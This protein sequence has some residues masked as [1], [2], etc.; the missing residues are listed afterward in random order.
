MLGGAAQGAMLVML[1]FLY[2]SIQSIILFFIWRNKINTVGTIKALK[3]TKF[4]Y[5]NENYIQKFFD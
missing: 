2:K 5:K 4:D 3:D 1:V